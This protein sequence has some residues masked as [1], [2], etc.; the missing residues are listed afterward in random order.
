M[1][2]S[3]EKR[4]SSVQVKIELY[5]GDITDLNAHALVSSVHRSKTLSRG[6]LS[7]H[8]SRKAGPSLQ[9]QLNEKIRGELQFKQIVTCNPG[10]L[11]NFNSVMFMCLYH[12]RDGNEVDLKHA[13][14]D[15]LQIA[16][17]KNYRT[18]AFPALGMGGN[19]YP[20]F[21]VAMAL[22]EAIITFVYD[23]P[24]T[25]LHTVYIA[26]NDP[27]QDSIRT[28][29]Q[30]VMAF[31][32]GVEAQ[33]DLQRTEPG[34]E[35]SWL[36]ISG[37]HLTELIRSKPAKVSNSLSSKALSVINCL[38]D[39]TVLYSNDAMTVTAQKTISLSELSFRGEVKIYVPAALKKGWNIVKQKIKE[40]LS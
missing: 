21:E 17:N 36:T 18:I 20:P 1:T 5:Q 19:Q 3:Q 2:F 29:V 24:G 7:R 37:Q 13:I 10:A 22:L 33:L 38:G 30:C 12:W 39:A 14:G 35:G 15:C 34:D 31:C 16:S 4:M 26:L 28:F 9:N 23:N 8:I 27:D 32:R 6:P 11:K 40:K 25:L